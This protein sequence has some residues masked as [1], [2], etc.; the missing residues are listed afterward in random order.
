V[1]DRVLIVGF[2]SIG[3]RHLKLLKELC[4]IADIRILTSQNLTQPE[5]SGIK[6]L[7]T[8]EDAISFHPNFAVIATPASTH[9]SIAKKLVE[10]G[11]HIFVEKP[12]STSAQ[13]VLEL[14]E[15][16]KKK[17]IVVHLGYNLRFDLAAIAFRNAIS[18]GLVG[19]IYIAHAEVGKYLPNWRTNRTYSE[20]VSAQKELGGGVLLEL[21][22]EIDYLHWIFGSV[23]WVKSTLGKVSKLEVDV[24]DFAELILGIDNPAPGM[25]SICTLRM[26][27]F[28]HN[29]T[30]FCV[31]I[32][33]LGTIQW[34]VE[35]GIVEILQENSNRWKVLFRSETTVE[36][37]YR[38]QW[39]FF[40]SK[41]ELGQVE[42][43]F[44]EGLRVL[45]VIDA[46]RV[47]AISGMQT[48]TSLEFP[49]NGGRQ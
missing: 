47:S 19:D 9:L 8:I 29:K 2:G 35:E 46:S 14:I 34:R 28:R 33:E 27:F 24:E 11:I 44:L 38:S 20:G 25:P 31:A 7:T 41:L 49:K 37:S 3:K 10:A 4:P 48:R 21:S 43:N 12:L 16:C 22:H 45:E 42:S 32:G 15:L 39:Q 1:I 6:I 13:G 18:Q 36:T 26:D 5:I 23:S 40:L 30:R 17:N